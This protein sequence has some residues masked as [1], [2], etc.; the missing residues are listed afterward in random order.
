MKPS[1]VHLALGIILLAVGIYA[2]VFW[3]PLSGTGFNFPMSAMNL[4]PGLAQLGFYFYY[5]A[6]P[7]RP[8]DW[9][10]W[11]PTTVILTAASLSMSLVIWLLVRAAHG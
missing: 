8:G 5:R 3:R 11:L 1:F 9:D 7:K 10:V 2:G 6:H 4:L